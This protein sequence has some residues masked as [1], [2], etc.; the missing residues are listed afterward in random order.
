MAR[1]IRRKREV[2]GFLLLLMLLTL[3]ERVVSTQRLGE[4]FVLMQ[5]FGGGVAAVMVLILSWMLGRGMAVQR[6][7]STV[8]LGRPARGMLGY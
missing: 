5:R 8:R 3:A 2:L 4:R 1:R 7:V 6:E